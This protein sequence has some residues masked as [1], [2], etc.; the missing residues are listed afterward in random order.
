[1]DGLLRGIITPMTTPFKDGRVDLAGLRANTA[2]YATTHLCGLFVAGSNG[3]NRSLTDRE[4][5]EVLS[6]VLEGRVEGQAVIAGT[7][8]E[9]TCQTIALSREAEQLGADYVA[10]LTPSY[11]RKLLTDDVLVG[12]YKDV[13]DAINIPVLI[14]NAPAFTG[15][16]ISP[17][18]VEALA[19]HPN[20]YGI[21]DSAPGDSSQYLSVVGAN[22]AVFSG[23][24]NQLYP[25]MMLGAAGGV[26]S[27]A[28]AFPEA[29]C[30]LY[31][32]VA[33]GDIHEAR[34]CHFR[35]TRLNH[36]I[37]GNFGVAGVKYA[38]DRAGYVGGLPRLPLLPLT[39]DQK[40]VIDMALESASMI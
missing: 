8:H 17:R 40:R 30:D 15:M 27:L 31:D 19:Q 21:K 11:F 23:T 5:M 22:F 25:A 18:A 6:A 26:V 24:I 3:E 33:R 38:M 35:L 20:I 39:D 37:S 2:R 1:M 16:A 4:K 29:C 9:S 32:T 10:V 13:A 28:N 34:R 7:G 36:A 14:Y 12:Y